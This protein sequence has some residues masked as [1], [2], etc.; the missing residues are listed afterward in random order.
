MK[1]DICTG[2]IASLTNRFEMSD[3]IVAATRLADKK[4]WPLPDKIKD[5]PGMFVEG[6]H[7]SNYYF[8]TCLTLN[9][10]LLSKPKKLKIIVTHIIMKLII[11]Y[12]FLLRRFWRATCSDVSGALPNNTGACRSTSGHDSRRMDKDKDNHVQEV[13]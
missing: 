3:D 11:E 6:T 8:L 10:N 13:T 5:E 9:S 1:K 4:T 2:V 12:Y 7:S